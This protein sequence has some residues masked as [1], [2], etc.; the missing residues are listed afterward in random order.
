MS[1]K[2]ANPQA[3]EP[4]LP[5]DGDG[6]ADA[7]RLPPESS[8]ATE[9]PAHP[10]NAEAPHADVQRAD[11]QDAAPVQ[12]E[13][14][15]EA[16][17]LV[18][19]PG[20]GV[21]AAA[22]VRPAPPRPAPA[23]PA[24]VR[25]A[26]APNRP[27]AAAPAARPPETVPL[28]PLAPKPAPT[29]PHPFPELLEFDEFLKGNR[30]TRRRKFLTKLA[31]FVGVPTLLMALYVFAWASPRYTSEFEITY[32]SYQNT[33]SLSQGLVQSV[34]GGSSAGVDL[35]TIMYEYIRSD[36]LLR[37]LDAKLNV[38]K[39][40][41]SDV[42]DYPVR[43]GSTA[44]DEKFL[45]YYRAHI[46]NVTQGL[47]GYLTVDVQ[48]FD[49]KFAQAIAT[50]IVESSDE[51]I[52]QM[53]A[54]ARRDEMKFAEE[55]VARQEGRVRDAQI[56]ETRFQNQ[57]RDLN[58]TNTANQYGQIIA[59]LETQ[60]SQA[61]TALTNTLSYASPNAPQVQQLKNQI[62]AV[63]AQLKEQKDRLTG[64]GMTYS[65][66]L[67]EYSRLQLE[68]TFAQNAYQLAQ[69][70]LSVA[71]AD[72][73]KK[74]SYLVDFVAPSTPSAPDHDFYVTYLGY[75]FFGS[76]V[77]YAITS[78]LAGAFRDQAGF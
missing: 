73:A 18:V 61:R 77:L 48:A 10:Q 47:G 63:E 29:E 24:P 44:S 59:S 53:T 14:A 55:E 70:G 17:R 64:S 54:R 11:V 6:A 52:D 30:L 49:P 37:K 32:Q 41:S 67:E 50:A 51:M 38:R 33:Q 22:P 7:S 28:R 21:A 56:A 43:L 1:E 13:P 71:R 72:A 62:A 26:A 16:P 76:L 8:R 31:L 75:A 5:L 25:P 36:T 4:L 69:Q 45:N 20:Q 57:H 66:I 15:G 42:V 9:A 65:Q 27:V 19:V 39:Y 60:L 23:R 68:V 3:S 78:L 2:Q 12:I 40:Y 74:Q 58:P 46:I 35:S 34:L